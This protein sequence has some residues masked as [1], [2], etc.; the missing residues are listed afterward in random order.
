MIRNPAKDRSGKSKADPSEPHDIGPQIRR[1]RRA[2][3]LSQN[4]LAKA[5]GVSRSAI[6]LWE[7]GSRSGHVAKH[8]Q[9]AA[10]LKVGL[11]EITKPTNV[12]EPLAR[13]ISSDEAAFLSFFESLN[14]Q[15][16]QLVIDV[17]SQ[18]TATKHRR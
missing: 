17:I 4:D 8:R 10:A 5:I 6:A 9:I 11:R 1:L 12:A 3:G 2:R 16:K 15:D 13:K 7:T 14:D 18:F